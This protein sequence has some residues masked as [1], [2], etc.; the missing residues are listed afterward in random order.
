MSGYHVGCAQCDAKSPVIQNTEECKQHGW[1]IRTVQKG[2]QFITD[3]ICP[4]H[5]QSA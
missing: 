2:A 5:R 4:A 1:I 3:F